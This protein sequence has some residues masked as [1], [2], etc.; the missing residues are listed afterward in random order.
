MKF[1]PFA[2]R[3][4]RGYIRD[5]SERELGVHLE[6]ALKGVIIADRWPKSTIDISV[7]ILEGEEDQW[8]GDAMNTEFTLEGCGLINIL[9]ACITVTSAALADAGID[10]L[11]LITGG[12]ASISERGEMWLDV[13]PS[14]HANLASTCTL[15]Y[16]SSRDEITEIWLKG[17]V[18]PDPNMPS[19][20]DN[21]IEGAV[22]A[23][24]AAY[25]ILQG[26]VKES[27]ERRAARIN[28]TPSHKK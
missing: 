7:T 14:D 3:S 24:R 12:S 19:N 16:M 20:I 28:A 10:C 25:S 23:A 26:A 22:M 15:A 18:S 4:R 27:A 1:S 5:T 13:S 2:S 6:T 11:D 21:L 9:S 8:W 17:D